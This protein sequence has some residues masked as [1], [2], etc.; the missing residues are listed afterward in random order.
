MK[1][2]AE[3]L[4]HYLIAALLLGF[5]GVAPLI[6]QNA[7]ARIKRTHVQPISKEPSV[8]AGDAVRATLDNGMRVVVIRNPLAPLVTVEQNYLV[9]GD[10]SPEDFPG[11][12]HAQEHMA[13]RGCSG[14]TAD[15]ISAIFAQLGGS[16]DADTE[17]N[18]TQ[19][20]STV[21]A[22]DLDI[23]LRVDSACMQNIEDSQQEWIQE[24]GAIEQELASDLSDPKYKF[25]ARLNQ[26]MFAGTVYA[27]DLLGS[28]ESFDATTGE[29]LKEFYQDWYAPNNAILVIVG[30]VQPDEALGQ[31]KELYSGIPRKQLPGRPEIKLQPVKSESFTLD[32]NLPDL[33]TFIAYRMPGT[34]SEDFVAT[35]ILANVL[36]SERGNLYEMVPQGKAI[37]TGF[38]LAETY[39]M[40]SVAFA[41]AVLPAGEDPAPALAEMRKILRDYAVNGVPEGLVE[42]AKRWVIARSQ[43]RR[44]SIPG[45]AEAWSDALAAR[46]LNSPDEDVERTKRITVQDVNRVA[47]EYLTDSNSVTTT[48]KPVP[49]GEAVSQKGIGATE[50]LTS[51][52]TK[53]VALPLW[54]SSRLLNLEL[55]PPGPMPV[56]IVLPNGIRLIVRQVTVSPTV[57]LLGNVRHNS[58]MQ[59]PWGQEGISNVLDE[60]FYFG[61]KIHDRS[62]FQ[63]ALDDIA[64]DQSAGYDFSLEVLREDFSRGV[65]LLAENEISPALR[66]EA[67]RITQ[68]QMSQHIAG[69]MNSPAYR[70]GRAL[71]V[72][73][74]PPNDPDLREVTPQAVASLTLA[75]VKSYYVKTIRPDLTTI[76]VIGDVTPDD[77]RKVV[78]KWFGPWKA[79]G[80][81]PDLEL[82]AISPNKPS[83][84]VIS[85]PTQLQD[86]VNLSQ[87]IPI[88]RFDPDY[89]SLQLGNHVLGGGFYATRLYHD[90][91][92]TT[93]YVY[94]VD[95]DLDALETRTVYTVTY[96][97]DP[98]NTAN[99]RELIHRDLTT[100]QKEDVVPAELQ[101]AKALLLRQTPLDESSQRS[102]AAGLLG[103]AQLGL[104]LD[105]PERAAKIYFDMTADQVREAFAKWIRPDGFVQVVLGPASQY[106][107]E[108]MSMSSS[109]K[110]VRDSRLTRSASWERGK[111]SAPSYPTARQQMVVSHF[112][113]TVN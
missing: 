99:A 65:Q 106:A 75:D 4:I 85:D 26:D 51:T 2:Q 10:E 17:Q 41:S 97:S 6:S 33:Q 49:S 83:A 111:R 86:S 11:M 98:T 94:Y 60:L 81:K 93:G 13:F 42:A 14:L 37:L 74:L 87:M 61:T 40:G 102:I 57:T 78:E 105:E 53:P 9:G 67:I 24:K 110:P 38:D 101:Q 104:P 20:I 28:K 44:N 71:A 103:R 36:A 91:R 5:F 77:A 89:Y 15:Q 113:K 50:Q 107:G 7:T 18:I 92:Q 45:L 12:A 59:E 35:K 46:G 58:E 95:V 68:T 90:L 29:M 43:F 3:P 79:R 76:V 25:L 80:L 56:E 31:V 112:R 8:V 109:Y 63:K 48:L 62:S 54:A 19:Y 23:A 34:D 73:L 47:K 16:G 69:R 52:P 64:A 100:M 82:P 108:S 39:R 1:A 55:P 21:P 27:N 22:G 32:S 88:N 66:A 96:A 84:A 72:G 70:I 30:D